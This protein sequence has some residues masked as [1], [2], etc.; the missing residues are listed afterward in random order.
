M[1]EK[2]KKTSL[3][4][5]CEKQIEALKKGGFDAGKV[6]DTLPFPKYYIDYDS[7]ELTVFCYDFEAISFL[8]ENNLLND[9]TCAI[10]GN[11]P[12]TGD[13][14]T[15]SGFDRRIQISICI[16]CKTQRS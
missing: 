12:I 5:L 3:L 11:T 2:E 6:G 7:P 8:I 15:S 10:C 4:N 14:H 16:E 9:G 1:T 13:F